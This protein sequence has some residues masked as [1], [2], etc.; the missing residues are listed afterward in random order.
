MQDPGKDVVLALCVT[1]AID[2]GSMTVALGEDV[3][4]GFDSTTVAL[5]EGVITELGV[6]MVVVI[7]RA[8]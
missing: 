4:K 1:D 3:V 2:V 5:A 8:M 6:G 7:V